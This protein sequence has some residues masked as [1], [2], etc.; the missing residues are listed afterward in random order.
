[1]VLDFVVGDYVDEIIGPMLLEGP[2]ARSTFSVTSFQLH[3]YHIRKR[4]IY[5]NALGLMRRKEYIIH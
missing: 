5:A 3:P 4:C 2:L 1:M